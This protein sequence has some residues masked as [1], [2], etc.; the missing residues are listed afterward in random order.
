MAE[1]IKCPNCI[2]EELVQTLAN[3]VVCPSCEITWVQTSDELV[4]NYKQ[5][6]G[7]MFPNRANLLADEAQDSLPQL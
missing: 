7:I 3:L 2:N 4:P 1:Q 6:N 5:P